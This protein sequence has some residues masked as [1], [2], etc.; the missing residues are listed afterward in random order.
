MQAGARALV[1]ALSSCAEHLLMLKMSNVTLL[2]RLNTTENPPANLANLKELHLSLI[3]Y[4]H[5]GLMSL[6][7]YPPTTVVESELILLRHYSSSYDDIMFCHFN[8]LQLN[9]RDLK[10]TVDTPKARVFIQSG[11]FKESFV[12]ELKS[13]SWSV[14]L[15][16][17]R[18]LHLALP[19]QEMKSLELSFLDPV[20][21]TFYAKSRR[22]TP[23]DIPLL[24]N[25]L[26]EVT[27]L[28]RLQINLTNYPKEEE[29]MDEFQIR[30]AGIME[31]LHLGSESDR[32]PELQ[33]IGLDGF[34]FRSCGATWNTF[35][36][37]LSSWNKPNTSL[38]LD[39]SR[40]LTKRT[41]C[42][43]AGMVSTLLVDG[44]RV[45]QKCDAVTF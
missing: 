12:F 20:S 38:K 23:P 44:V 42:E 40:H 11:N 27:S 10:I 7:H 17:Y 19:F 43:I 33:E 37:A 36:N 34:N 35:T 45:E 41:R 30:I 1:T 16:I 14:M 5:A 24:K 9:T 39:K 28:R 32:L 21:H 18:H 8:V 6:F 31:S 29:N 3:G 26:S 22:N 2:S 25:I 4:N 13:V 15:E